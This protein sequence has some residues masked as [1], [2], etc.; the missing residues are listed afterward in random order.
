[1]G[2]VH[3]KNYAEIMWDGREVVLYR[4]QEFVLKRRDKIGD[5][6]SS[7]NTLKRGLIR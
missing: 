7:E 4:Q 1:L 2:A 6:L 3:T 5:A